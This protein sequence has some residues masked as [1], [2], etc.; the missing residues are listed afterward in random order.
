M[1]KIEAG[2]MDLYLETFFLPTILNEV[3]ST[4][5]PL[6][7]KKNNVLT[8]ALDD[9]LGDMY[10]DTTKLRQMLL[11]LMSNAAKFTENGNICFE[12]KRDGESIAFSVIDNGIGMTIEQQK[13]LF[14]PFT[15]ADSSMTRRYGG[16][17]LGLAI[18]KKFAQM[19]GGTLCVESE[20]EH[21]S[22]FV[23]FLPVQTKGCSNK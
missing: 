23:L 11:N 5:Q 19:L 6:L 3:I 17:G 22:T 21:G 14:Q 18:T 13:K 4:I 9:N 15:Q 20:F 10:S 16:T 8:L 2:K 12:V 1:S 7:T